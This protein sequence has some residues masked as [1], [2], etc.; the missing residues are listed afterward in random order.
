MNGKLTISSLLHGPE[1][2]PHRT[3]NGPDDWTKFGLELGPVNQ[4]VRSFRSIEFTRYVFSMFFGGIL[5]LI[6]T[7]APEAGHA[8]D[9]I[10]NATDRSSYDRD[11]SDSE[12]RFLFTSK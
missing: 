4:L 8:N 9:G 1:W 10:T 6:T 3:F 7:D 12:I 11:F 2:L 5:L